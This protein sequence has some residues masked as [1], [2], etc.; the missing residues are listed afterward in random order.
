MRIVFGT[1]FSSLKN[2]CLQLVR[3]DGLPFFW[4][5]LGSQSPDDLHMV[6]QHG[7]KAAAFGLAEFADQRGVD[8][9]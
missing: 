4:E 3:G 9:I 8:R 6:P 2:N 5:F 1:S 7:V